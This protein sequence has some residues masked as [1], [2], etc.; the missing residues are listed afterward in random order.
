MSKIILKLSIIG[1]L[2]LSSFP[3]VLTYAQNNNEKII[4]EYTP[5]LQI[6]SV[7][8]KA[9]KYAMTQGE[10]IEKYFIKQIKYDADKKGWSVFF[11][12]NL[13]V[14]GNHFSVTIKD[15]TGKIQLFLGE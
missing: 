15:R 9:K 12:G 6:E 2:L 10:K 13:P 14:P 8:Q 4:E 7:I 1:A 5:K 3:F 11:M